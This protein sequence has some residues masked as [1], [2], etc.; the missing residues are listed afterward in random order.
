MKN[1]PIETDRLIL[2][3]FREEDA[4]ALFELES[5][6]LVLKYLKVEP[7]KKFEEI[8]T[9]I[10]RVQKQ[11]RD[12]DIGR[13]IMEE[14]STGAVMGWTGLKLE[15][16]ETNGYSNYIDLGYRLNP[17]YWGLGYATESAKASVKYGFEVMNYPI[18]YGA[19]DVENIGS[20]RVLQKAGLNF[21]ES[22]DYEGIQHNWYELKSEDY[23]L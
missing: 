23:G 4:S 2:R 14:K 11:Y 3:E 12:N 7:L 18:I 20:N 17:N 21:V 1:L 10:E 13:W 16:M 8:F 5:N 22:F 9:I 15:P 19:A 6:P